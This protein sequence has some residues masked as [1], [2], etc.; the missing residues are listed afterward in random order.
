MTLVPEGTAIGTLPTRD[1]F[2]ALPSSST[3]V[4]ART[5]SADGRDALLLVEAVPAA[6]MARLRSMVEDC[7]DAVESERGE[8]EREAHAEGKRAREWRERKSERQRRLFFVVFS[9]P[10]RPPT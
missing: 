10:R 2:G 9:W 3:C 4:L 8:R 7:I 1:S 5:T 6:G